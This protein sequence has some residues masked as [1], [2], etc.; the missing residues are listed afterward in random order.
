MPNHCFCEQISNGPLAQPSNAWSGLFF[1]FA[2]IA[3]LLLACRKTK[4]H[5]PLTTRLGYAIVFAL[6]LIILLGGGTF[7]FHAKLNFLGQYI[8]GMGISLIATSVLFYRYG[9][10]HCKFHHTFGWFV[11]TNV[12]AFILVYKFHLARYIL[13]VVLGA[14]LILEVELRRK[15]KVEMDSKYLLYALASFIVGFVIWILD[16]Q[17]IVCDPTSHIQGHAIWHGFVALSGFLIFMYYRSEKRTICV[18]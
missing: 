1:V 15:Y 10:S 3:V 2:G 7:Y 8:D 4:N 5:N 13:G 14:V 18:K 11:V 12:L 16:I 9:D 17:K 6:I